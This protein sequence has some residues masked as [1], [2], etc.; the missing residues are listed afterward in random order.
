MYMTRVRVIPI[1]LIDRHGGLVKTIRFKK[2]TYIGDPINA[3]KIFND[4][5]V[6][7][8]IIVDIDATTDRRGLNSKFVQ[9]I[10]S[11]AFMPIS[12]GGGVADLQQM[13][14]LFRAG[15]E[16]VIICTAALHRPDLIRAAADAFGSQSVV[17][18]LDLQRNWRG[19]YR[20]RSGGPRNV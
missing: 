17:V 15:I 10:V 7:E 2:R 13:Q 14:A 5:Q 11:E 9:D 19:I 3:V 4:K 20:L 18:C 8:L 6:D 16:K 1:L 12:Y